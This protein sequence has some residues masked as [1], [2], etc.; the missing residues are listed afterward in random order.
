[1]KAGTY[2]LAR[3][4]ENPQRGRRKSDWTQVH[5]WEAGWVFVLREETVDMPEGFEDRKELRLALGKGSMYSLSLRDARTLALLPHLVEVLEEASDWLCR[6]ERGTS[7][8]PAIIDHLVA[9]GKI[10]RADVEAAFEYCL[11][12][13][14][15]REHTQ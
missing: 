2:R 8:T 10:S 1:M 9:S 6:T 14:Y 15:K 13:L 3:T 4:V 5:R 7:L 12:A 11:A